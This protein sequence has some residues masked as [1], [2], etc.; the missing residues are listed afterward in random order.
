MFLSAAILFALTLQGGQRWFRYRR[1]SLF[2]V[3]VKNSGAAKTV[4][5]AIATC[6]SQYH[7]SSGRCRS[8]YRT[9]I[10]CVW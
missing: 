7:E 1:A 4:Q 2:F 6:C 10:A 8:L 5:G 9:G 3:G